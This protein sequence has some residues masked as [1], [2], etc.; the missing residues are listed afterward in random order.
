[1]TKNYFIL[2]TLICITTS[3]F[4][5]QEPTVNLQVEKNTLADILAKVE[6]QSGV[7]FY[8]LEDWLPKD[9]LTKNY[10]NT[11]LADVLNDLFKETDLQY[12]K[13]SENHIYLTRGRLIHDYLPDGFFPA[14][15]DTTETQQEY[16]SD[17][18]ISVVINEQRS[19]TRKRKRTIQIG[20]QSSGPSASEFT[21][22]GK[23]VNAQSGRPVS[24]VLLS[25]GSGLTALTD[26]AGNYTFTLPYGENTLFADA[27]GLERLEQPIIVYGD[28][29]LEIVLSESVEQLDEVVV[30]A[31]SRSII[32]ATTTGKNTIDA[33]ESKT[34]PVVL[35]ERDLLKIATTLP[36][37]TTSGEGSA[38]FNV[39]GGKTDQNLV[40]LDNS[41][42]YNPSHFFGIF[43][44]LNPFTVETIDIYKGNIPAEYGGR[45][46][47]VFKITTKVPDSEKI[48]GEASIGPVTGNVKLDIPIVKE[49]AGLTLAGRGTYSDWIL[50]TLDNEDLQGRSAYFFDVLAKYHHKIN[51]NNTIQAQGYYSQDAFSITQDSLYSY[52]NTLASLQWDHK[53]SEKSQAAV[54][55]T[56]SDYFFEI[57]FE[58]RPQTAFNYN[59][60]IRETEFKFK[61]DYVPNTT[62]S[63]TYGVSTKLYGLEPGSIR[64]LGGESQVQSRDV[65]EEQGLESA[66]FIADN[67]TFSEKFQL[68]LGLRYSIFNAIGPGEQRIYADN[69]PRN[70]TSLQETQEIESGEFFETYAFPEFWVGARYSLNRDLSIKASYSSATQYI[71]SLSN[72]TTVSPIDTWKLSDNNI[73]PQRA[74]I[75]SAGVYKFFDDG[76]YEVSVEGFYKIQDNILDFKVGADIILN[77]A[78]EQETLQGEGKSYGGELLIRKNRGKLTGWLGYT[79]SRAFFK[80]DSEFPEELVS[81]GEF[82]PAN[83][84]KPHDVSLVANYAITKRL[85]FSTNFTY[86][87]GR[88]VTFPTG[89]FFFNGEQQVL[90]S[91]RNSFRIPDYYRLDIGLNLEGNHK[92]NKLAHSFW[93]LSIYNVLGRNNPYS[94]FFVT[95]N[96]EVKAFQSSIFNIPIPSITYNIRF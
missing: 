84:D 6:Q 13:Y 19:D 71:H 3:L 33:E 73:E 9:S 51:E 42:I 74:S 70:E 91:Q 57:D 63:L 30:E 80:L 1:M 5:Q 14:P 46:S 38:G 89:T 10:Q 69:A 79:Y 36:G 41:V 85:S 64:G 55:L 62:H 49:K 66:V 48:S 87:T 23:V 2:I 82:F 52:D 35:G 22:N 28:G 8:Y 81:N 95:E 34:I 26:A 45:L 61:M 68:E 76:L 37:I 32:E 29:N 56:H 59:F 77:E 18:N 94:V 67:I 65:D 72:N 54:S 44:A 16:Y 17:E 20:K 40:L 7:R 83:F 39:R 60:N 27:L 50:G 21:L 31:D 12:F 43:Q 90:Y 4:G 11:K 25:T 78:I 58:G 96:A 92:K 47:S 93:S 15:A 53:F 75:F 88:P 24:G 86:Q